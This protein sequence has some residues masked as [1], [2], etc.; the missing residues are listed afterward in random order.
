[1]K[2]LNQKKAPEAVPATKVD[3]SAAEAALAAKM[4]EMAQQEKNAQAAAKKQA[5]AQA[6]LDAK[7]KELDAQKPAPTP[8]PVVVA[9]A[10]KPAPAPAPTPAP[11]PVVVPATAPVVA[12]VPADGNRHA[13]AQDALENKMA[14]MRHTEN[15]SITGIPV[16]PPTARPI[17]LIEAERVASGAELSTSPKTG[18]ERLEEISTLYRSN[19]MTPQEYHRERAQIIKSLE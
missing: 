13:A 7:M 19:L 10:P 8:A 3:R 16:A 15:V 12:T 1:M 6:V 9:P 11:A 18:M 5:A 17:Q 4:A 2:D 14:D